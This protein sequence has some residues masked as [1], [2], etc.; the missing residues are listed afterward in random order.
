MFAVCLAIR[1][2]LYA[3]VTSFTFFVLLGP[4]GYKGSFDALLGWLPLL[5][6]GLAGALLITAIVDLASAVFFSTIQVGL[7]RRALIRWPESSSGRSL[8]IAAAPPA[9]ASAPELTLER[10]SSRPRRSPQCCCSLIP[11]SC[12]GPS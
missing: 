8:R 2:A 6:H 5:P 1:L 7:Y 12:L 10:R 4:A 11:G 3:V 9:P